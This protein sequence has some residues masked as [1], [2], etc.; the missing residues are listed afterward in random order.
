MSRDPINPTP[1]SRAG[2]V[3][4]ATASA[5]SDIAAFV[6]KAR[7]MTPGAAGARGRLVFAL[8]ATLSRQPTWDMACAL[9][10]DMFRE[11]AAIGNL[12]IRLVYFRGLNECRAS[13]WI[14]DSTKLASLMTRIRCAGGQT[15]IGRVL[16]DTRRE[17]VASGV[18]ALVFVGDAMEE[19]VDALCATAGE[20]G[21]LKVPVFLFQEGHDVAAEQA[22]REI[23]RLTGGA[24]CRFDPGASTQLRDLLRAAAAYAAGGREALMRLSKTGGGAAALLGQMR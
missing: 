7:A 11:A 15:Q 20:L 23:A 6:A 14:S 4:D 18:R 16:S 21:L 3:P 24:W 5:S 8:D 10:A 9:Q 22:F 13:G 19:S 17:A 1:A 12:D 2:T